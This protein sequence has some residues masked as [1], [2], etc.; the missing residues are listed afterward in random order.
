MNQ[1][2]FEPF[3]LQK[4]DEYGILAQ[5]KAKVEVKVAY[6]RQS[7][8]AKA[9]LCQGKSKLTRTELAWRRIT[10]SGGDFRLGHD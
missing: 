7:R 4:N 8:P 5:T 6:Q 1:K 2:C 3:M 10:S 9:R